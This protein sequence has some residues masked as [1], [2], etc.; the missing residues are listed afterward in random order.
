MDPKSIHLLS[1]GDL[2]AEDL[3]GLIDHG[4]DGNVERKRQLPEP[5]AF[6]AA[7]N[8]FANTVGGWVLLGVDDDRSIHG[9]EKPANLDLQSHLAARLRNEADPLPPFVA[10]MRPV[11]DKQICAVRVFPSTSLPHIVRG[12]GAVYVRTSKGKEPI[13]D[14]RVLIEL[15]R[16]GERAEQEARARLTDLSVI[17]SALVPPDAPQGQIARSGDP[18][19]TKVIVRAAPVLVTPQFADWPISE[20]GAN[21][22]FRAVTS[23]P[24]PGDP[25]ANAYVDAH[26][27]GAVARTFTEAALPSRGT[28]GG[29]VA[30]DSAGL[31]GAY[32]SRPKRGAEHLPV[33]RRELI[34]PLIDLVADGLAQAEAYGRAVMDMWLCLPGDVAVNEAQRHQPGPNPDATRE[35]E[36]HASGEVTIPSSEEETA[37]LGRQWERELARNFGIHAWEGAA[38]AD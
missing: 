8:S 3:Q 33:L 37:A 38:S 4:E 27:R 24:L 36:I 15:A 30:A 25:T 13:D 6:G 2:T 19:N 18:N 14:Q 1:L 20:R 22:C 26:G 12:T 7:V 16:R 9:F 21:W 5:P 17:Y 32:L 34:R 10:D 28:F 35:V 29:T 11:G 31:I 23:I